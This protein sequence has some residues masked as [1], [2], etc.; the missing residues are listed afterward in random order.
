[1]AT[2]LAGGPRSAASGYRAGPRAAS[3]RLAELEERIS[4]FRNLAPLRYQVPVLKGGI[5]PIGVEREVEATDDPLGRAR[6]PQRGPGVAGHGDAARGSA[7]IPRERVP[8]R[9]LRRLPSLGRI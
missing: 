7:E 5:N 3:L 6:C 9:T 8:R 1:M 4:E 2:R